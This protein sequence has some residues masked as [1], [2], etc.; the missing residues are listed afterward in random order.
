MTDLATQPRQL[1]PAPTRSVPARAFITMMDQCVS[2]ASNFAVAVVVARLAGVSG[3]GAFSLAYASWLLV[4][5]LHRALV[6]DP[7]AIMGDARHPTDA[8]SNLR[9]GFASE[10]TLG[11]GAGFIVGLIGVVLLL[12]GQR[13]FG[14]SQLAVAPWITFLLLQDYWRWIGFMQATPGKSLAN[15]IVFDLVQ[16]AGFVFLLVAHIHSA[17]LAIAAWGLG[18]L[19]GAVYGLWQFRVK[20]SVIGGFGWLRMKWPVSKWL[21]A[22]STSSWGLT[23]IFAILAAA[24]LGP[25]GLG[26]LKAAQGLVSGPAYVL[27][28]AGGSLGLPEASRAYDKKGWSGLSRV[29]RVVT[30]AGALGVGF[31]TVA[32]ILIGRRLLDAFYGPQFGRYE[33]VAIVMSFA[34]LIST[35][36]VG[37]ILKLKTTKQTHLLFIVT[38]VALVPSTLAVIVLTPALGVVG[39]A[40]AYAIGTLIYV[41][42]L[43][44]AARSVSR[45]VRSGQIAASPVGEAFPEGMDGG[46]VDLV[47]SW[48]AEHQ[49][50]KVTPGRGARP[51]PLPARSAAWYADNERVRPAPS[52]GARPARAPARSAAHGP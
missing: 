10:V 3:L 2:S 45:R 4:S 12:A 8:R 44:I 16:G 30:V 39:A 25:V 9:K 27:V 21:A 43:M 50:A 41:A 13:S 5:A 52:R 40:D 19:G 34:Y 17:A 28:Q 15:D 26:G 6:T 36:S 48:Y 31:V 1:T 37:A 38:T 24:F 47:L 11:V 23:Q 14:I 22:T 46:G 20:P 35:F 51:G 42:G 7:M 32:V 18:A 49:R 29:T 33:T